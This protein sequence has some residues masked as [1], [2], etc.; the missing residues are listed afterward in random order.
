MV[1]RKV[2]RRVEDSSAEEGNTMLTMY[3][4]ASGEKIAKQEYY[5]QESHVYYMKLW[6]DKG[7]SGL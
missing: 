5:N 1:L 6:I 4:Y 2:E 7:I 3:R